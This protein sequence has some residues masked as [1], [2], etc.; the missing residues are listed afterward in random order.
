[1]GL[2]GSKGMDDD[3][4]AEGMNESI[5]SGTGR[6]WQWQRLSAGQRPWSSKILLHGIGLCRVQRPIAAIWG[7]CAA[8][9]PVLA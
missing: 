9:I 7:C 1:M 6:A 4:I 5:V 8:A 2:K 3:Y